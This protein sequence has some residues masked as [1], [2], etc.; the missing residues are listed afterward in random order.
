VISDFDIPH[1]PSN[2]L[3]MKVPLPAYLGFVQHKLDLRLEWS[4][5]YKLCDLKPALGLLHHD[6]TRQYEFWGDTDMDLVYGDVL[7]PYVPFMDE[8]DIISS[9]TCIAAGH[10]TVYRTMD[11]TLTL[12]SRYP[13]WREKFSGGVHVHYDE[14]YMTNLL[15]PKVKQSNLRFAER[16]VTEPVIG[17][18]RLKALFKE[19]YTTYNGED[20]LLPGGKLAQPTAWTWDRGVVSNDVMGPGILYAHFSHWNSG[21]WGNVDAGHAGAWKSAGPDA[22]PKRPYD[23]I[24]K[25]TVSHEGFKIIE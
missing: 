7:G 8:F 16:F 15:M 3:H 25:F 21:R 20:W 22:F 23:E 9:H 10:L 5:A 6:V 18:K 4:D 19:Q 1:R 12:F 2:I 13:H 14:R 17:G 24:R 11:E